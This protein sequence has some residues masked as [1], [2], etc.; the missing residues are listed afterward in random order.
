MKKDKI[1]VLDEVLSED[2]IKSFLDLSAPD[3]EN[4]DFHCLQKAY[5]GMPPQYFEVFLG[6]YSSAGRDINARSASGASLLEEI[7][8]HKQADAYTK[9]LQAADAK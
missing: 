4:T 6:F 3:G 9:L 1:K 7:Q 5:R 8:N 2:R